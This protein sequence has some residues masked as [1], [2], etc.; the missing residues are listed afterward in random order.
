MERI[1]RESENRLFEL[2]SLF[3]RSYRNKEFETEFFNK[4]NY[5][6]SDAMYL[7]FDDIKDEI[8]KNLRQIEGTNPSHERKYYL[9]NLK[10]RFL[11]YNYIWK[12]NQYVNILTYN[13][14]LSLQK[15]NINDSDLEFINKSIL[16]KEFINETISYI[17]SNLNKDL[18]LNENIISSIIAPKHEE[19]AKYEDFFI[20][21]DY[22]TL[23]EASKFRKERFN[24]N[25]VYIP[26]YN[27]VFTINMELVIILE[28]MR[29]NGLICEVK[30]TERSIFAEKWNFNTNGQLRKIKEIP[31][32]C[33]ENINYFRNLLPTN[34]S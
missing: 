17:N 7:A 29:L 9:F 20:K 6:L 34:N 26:S 21:K 14:L 1:N 32:N 30:Q 2:F 15:H 33:T 23:F 4:N 13:D 25:N 8:F 18:N 24:E 16:F 27:K 3:S 19:P 31:Q 5:S 11:N 12:N 28:A 10:E 22:L